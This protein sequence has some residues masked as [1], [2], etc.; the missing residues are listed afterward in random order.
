MYYDLNEEIRFKVNNI[1]FN[2]TQIET[3][4]P[5]VEAAKKILPP[6]PVQQQGNVIGS[7]P[8][9]NPNTLNGPTQSENKEDE[10]EDQ[11]K[12]PLVIYGRINDS[13]LGLTS[14]WTD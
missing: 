13:G 14:W 9:A 7:I 2:T 11:S 6:P 4:A 3:Q 8:G 1:Q 12:V 10:I 5:K